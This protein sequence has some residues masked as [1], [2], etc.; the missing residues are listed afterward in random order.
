MDRKDIG[1]WLQGPKA[2]LENQGVD[3]GYPGER[4]GLPQVGPGAVASMGRRAVALTIDWFSSMAIAGM[5]FPQVSYNTKSLLILEVFAVQ[6]ILLTALTGSS[7]GQRIMN[8]RIVNVSGA[9]LSLPRVLARTWLLSWVVPALI[10]DRDGRGL[11]DKAVE[12]V[13]VRIR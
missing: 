13:A 12:S 6:V 11:H 5:V 8:V 1:S 10:W 2:A 4:L 7:F 3:F 9:R